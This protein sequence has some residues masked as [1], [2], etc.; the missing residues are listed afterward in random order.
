MAGA[1]S[2]SSQE[3]APNRRPFIARTRERLSPMLDGRRGR[4]LRYAAYGILALIAAPY[5]LALL[6]IFI[7]PP[8]SFY[9]LREAVAGE[10]ARWRWKDIEEISP[11]LTKQVIVSE[12]ARFCEHWGVDWHA[13]IDA[14]EDADDGRPR[15]AS[16][17]S[18]QTAKNAFLWNEPAYLRKVFEL[19][20]AYF[21][22]FVWGKRRLMEIYLNIAEWGP[23]I[24]GAEA[25]ARHHFGKSASNLTRQEAAQL[26][27]ALPNP[28]RRN[29]GSPGPRTFAL[30]SRLRARA[31]RERSA[32]ACVLR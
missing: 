5:V 20:L 2:E 24:F 12:D 7:N 3:N 26:A 30:A 29:A 28:I 4:L 22:D 19:P 14:V 10:G 32:A 25:A 18:M 23:G 11:N 27:A 1:M 13:V 9:M 8:M 21:I 15:G 6:Y 17:I 16:T 31:G